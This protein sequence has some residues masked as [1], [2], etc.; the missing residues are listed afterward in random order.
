[1]EVI[2]RLRSWTD[3]VGEWLDDQEN[4]KRQRTVR[5]LCEDTAARKREHVDEAMDEATD[6]RPVRRESAA[7]E[8]PCNPSSSTWIPPCFRH[9]FDSFAGRR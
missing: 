5:Q 8:A 9:R 1:M 7:D 6:R 2:K 3:D 4:S